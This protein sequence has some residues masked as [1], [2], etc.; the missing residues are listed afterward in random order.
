MR[1][2]SY[3]KKYEIE[4]L[5]VLPINFDSTKIYPLI[6]CIHGGPYSAFKQ[7]LIQSY[8]MQAYANDGYIVLAPN[9]RGSSGYSDEFGQSNQFDLGGG[10]Y[11]D[12]MSSVDFM[13][14]KGIVDTTKMGVTGGSYGG[15][16]TNWIISQTNRFSAAVSMY[17]I[18]SFFTDFSNSWQPIFEKMYFGYYYWERP[19]DWNNLFISRSPAFFVES[20]KTPVLILQGDQDVYTNIANSQEMYQALKALGR[21]VQYVV[22][23]REGH[24]IRNE[25]QHYLNM[26]TK[27]LDWF[28][29]YLK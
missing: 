13:I 18:F 1:F 22:Y 23:P 6:L 19:I 9:V 25:P 5:T 24:G 12:A 4:V 15:F 17:G 3:D 8:P 10:D 7:T 14:S 11:L 21:D 27:G 29:K 26:L 20:I 16:L 28:N 2:Q